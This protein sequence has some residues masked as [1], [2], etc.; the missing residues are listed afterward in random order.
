MINVKTGQDVIVGFKY[1]GLTS[2]ET[3]TVERVSKA[4]G[5]FYTEFADYPY[6]L[7]TGVNQND[8]FGAKKYIVTDEAEIEKATAQIE[9]EKAEME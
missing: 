1:M 3:D 4:K 2:Y 5:E 6:S 8:A 7:E 9:A